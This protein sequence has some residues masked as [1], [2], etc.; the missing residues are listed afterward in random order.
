MPRDTL[1]M[2][3][4]EQL[5][6]ELLIEIGEDPDREDLL[7]TPRRVAQSL[8]YLTSGN[9]TDPN[10]LIN[11][12]CFSQETE[13]MVIE[14][15]IELYSL[16]EH[17][18]LPFFGR[19]H[20]GYIPNGKVFGISKMARLVDMYARRLQIQERLTE[21]VSHA[22][23]KATG[24]RGVGVLIESRHLCML[25]RGVEKQNSLVVTSSLLGAFRDNAS[26]RQEFLNLLNRPRL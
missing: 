14:R 11:S 19:C 12:A 17:H 8:A 1:N 20:I 10:V 3:R 23:M 16:C 26:T 6:R 25:M 24:A 2:E 13:S 5:V 21:Q 22:I 7:R 9:R 4:I 18:L 15:D